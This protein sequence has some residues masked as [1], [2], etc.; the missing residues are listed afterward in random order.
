MYAQ[1]RDAPP[2]P[3]LRELLAAFSRPRTSEDDLPAEV[4]P[5]VRFLDAAL[6]TEEPA[7]EAERRGA[8]RL[9]LLGRVFR[10]EL[11]AKIKAELEALHRKHSE[12]QGRH[13][14]DESRLLLR[15]LGVEHQRLYAI[16]TTTGRVGFYL[17]GGEP[18]GLNGS[19]AAV[20]VVERG[21]WVAARRDPSRLR[22][23]AAYVGR[24]ATGRERARSRTRV[25]RT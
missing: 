1:S 19:V 24:D 5:R 21:S 12:E 7:E 13:L 25:A 16:P 15:D 23:R 17:V 4:V 6:S 22:A 9:P 20:L 18:P 11:D 10:R 3:P 14:P 8:A 2:P